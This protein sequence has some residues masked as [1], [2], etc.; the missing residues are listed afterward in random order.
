MGGGGGVEEGGGILFLLICMY[1]EN[2]AVVYVT[3][4]APFEVFLL[5]I[6]SLTKMKWG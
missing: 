2:V 4:T 3:I 1:S 6:K 5:N